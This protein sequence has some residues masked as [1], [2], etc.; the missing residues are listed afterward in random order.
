MDSAFGTKE[1][2][3]KIKEILE[4]F[5]RRLDRAALVKKQ[6]R[7]KMNRQFSQVSFGSFSYFILVLTDPFSQ[8]VICHSCHIIMAMTFFSY[9]S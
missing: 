2:C 5:H 4:D 9:S 3:L 8:F 7:E 1:A 6:A